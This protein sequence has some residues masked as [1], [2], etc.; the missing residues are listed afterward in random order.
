MDVEEDMGQMEQRGGESHIGSNED[1][2]GVDTF[3]RDNIVQ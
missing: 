1:D 2:L 3:I